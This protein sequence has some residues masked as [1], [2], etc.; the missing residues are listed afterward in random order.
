MAFAGQEI[1]VATFRGCDD[2]SARNLH[3]VFVGVAFER[4]QLVFVDNNETGF[5]AVDADVAWALGPMGA[6][7]TCSLV[8]AFSLNATQGCLPR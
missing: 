1:V 5:A 2:K 6:R 3:S 8:V 7:I 4:S